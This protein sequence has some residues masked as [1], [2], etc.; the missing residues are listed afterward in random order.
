M[1][2][3][4]LEDIMIKEIFEYKPQKRDFIFWLSE[5]NTKIFN[6]VLKEEAKKFLILDEGLNKNRK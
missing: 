3:K 5:E 6:E 2:N 4:E 1:S